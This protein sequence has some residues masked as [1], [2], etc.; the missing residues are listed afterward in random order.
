MALTRRQR[1]VLD[2]I[3]EFIDRNYI[4]EG[5]LR[6]AARQNIQRLIEINCYRGVRHERGH[7]VRGQKSKSNGRTGLT[8][9][10]SRKAKK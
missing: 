6:K 1:Q 8:L 4:V 2:V 3:R 9:G 10:V 5:E 7:K